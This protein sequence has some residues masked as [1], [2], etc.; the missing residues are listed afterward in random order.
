LRR[1]WSRLWYR[2]LKPNYAEYLEP[3]ADACIQVDPFSVMLWFRAHGAVCVSHPTLSSMFL[4][5]H[6]QPLV[7]RR[8]RA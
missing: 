8:V 6:D 5:S 7:F 4:A 1:D 3:D 2:F